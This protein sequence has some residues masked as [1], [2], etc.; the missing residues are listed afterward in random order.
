MVMG[1][2]VWGLEVKFVWCGGD[3]VGIGQMGRVWHVC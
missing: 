3:M 1:A 2:G